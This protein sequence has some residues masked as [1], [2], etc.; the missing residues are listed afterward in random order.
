[1]I[2]ASY[3]HCTFQGCP[4]EKGK[5]L[6]ARVFIFRWFIFGVWWCMIGSLV[7]NRWCT[8][9]CAVVHLWLTRGSLVKAKFKSEKIKV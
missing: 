8:G 5:P 4:L 7:V 9:G 3:P 2:W 1:M 6:Q